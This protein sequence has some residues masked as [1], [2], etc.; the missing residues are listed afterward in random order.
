MKGRKKLP[1][2]IKEL[3]GTLRADRQLKDEMKPTKIV[4]LPYPPE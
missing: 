1:T 2:E 4:D 3:K